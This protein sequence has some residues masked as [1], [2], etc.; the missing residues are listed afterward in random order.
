VRFFEVRYDDWPGKSPKFR[1]IKAR[2]G[3]GVTITVRAIADDAAIK[4]YLRAI[5]FDGLMA[6]K[7]RVLPEPANS[8]W[9]VDLLGP[10]KAQEPKK[11]DKPKV[12]INR[13]L[14]T[15]CQSIGNPHLCRPMAVDLMK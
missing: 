14:R 12:K 11:D 1:R 15:D 4:H 2:L 5:D 7:P 6:A 3:A 10:F 13:G 8:G 9:V